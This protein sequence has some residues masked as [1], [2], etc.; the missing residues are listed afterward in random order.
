[1]LPYTA[2]LSVLGAH[3]IRPGL[4]FLVAVAV[5]PVAVV[6]RVV[7]RAHILHLQNIPAL[8]ASLNGAVAGH[9]G[10]HI[11]RVLSTFAR[12]RSTYREPGRDVGIS[13]VSRATGVLLVAE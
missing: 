11:R 8:G 9:L 12:T 13:R 1:M 7:L 5:V 6:M 10:T 2:H 4:G 3:V